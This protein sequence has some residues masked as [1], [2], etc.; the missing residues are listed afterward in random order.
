M[1]VY[2]SRLQYGLSICLS[3]FVCII[4]A[5]ISICLYKPAHDYCIYSVC[6]PGHHSHVCLVVYLS[7]LNIF[8]TCLLSCLRLAS[9]YNVCLSV[10]RLSFL[11]VSPGLTVYTHS[12]LVPCVSLAIVSVSFPSVCLSVSLVPHVSGDRFHFPPICVCLWPSYPLFFPS[13]CLSVSGAA[14]VS[15]VMSVFFLSVC[16]CTNSHLH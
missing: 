11:S 16:L 12:S 1:F 15:L 2:I 9:I 3:V 13:V 14:C 4:T 6:P 7:L 10:C 5:T 8:C